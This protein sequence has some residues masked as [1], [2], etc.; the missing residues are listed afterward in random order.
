MSNTVERE[1]IT[2]ELAGLSFT[3]ERPVRKKSRVV[4]RELM[5]LLN[6]HPSLRNP[7][8]TL[9]GAIDALM[10]SDDVLEFFYRTFEGMRDKAE[11]VDDATEREIM[12]ALT[13]F[14]EFVMAPFKQAGALPMN[15]LKPASTN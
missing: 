12:G 10:L 4:V 6:E 13:K 5:Q 3:W 8:A 14:S 11:I 2:I 1:S 7:E 9:D 15:T